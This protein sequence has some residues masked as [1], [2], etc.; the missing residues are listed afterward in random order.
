M[1]SIVQLPAVVQFLSHFERGAPACSYYV[2]SLAALACISAASLLSSVLLAMID[3]CPPD[4]LAATY[5]IR[6]VCSMTGVHPVTLRAWE[7]RYGLIKPRRTPGGHR[8]Y[9]REQI[10]QIMRARVMLERGVSI[11]QASRT[12][13]RAGIAGRRADVWE[14]LQARVIAA[15]VRFDEPALDAEY[16]SALALQPIE[17]VTRKL[18]LPVL[19]ELGRRWEA[20]EGNVAEEHFFA[21]YMRNKLGARLHHRPSVAPDSKLL[22]ACAP[23]EQHEFGLLLF[24]LAAHDAGIRCILLGADMPIDEL[25]SASRRASCDGI[26]ISTSI[27]L[28]NALLLEALTRVAASA[29]KPVFVGGLGSMAAD[30]AIAAAGAIAVGVDIPQGLRRIL[31]VLDKRRASR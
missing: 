2:S 20:A 16:E 12:L 9:T 1:E 25:P 4:P 27:G 10:D 18:V 29:R 3:R 13:R 7:R 31:Q 8:M 23:G 6:T 14:T 11:R 19:E 26:V 22:C 24:A 30:D 28:H 15:I 17:A 21:M 5:P